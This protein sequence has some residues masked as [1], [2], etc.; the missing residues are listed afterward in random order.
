MEAATLYLWDSEND[1]KLEHYSSLLASI[2][3][4]RPQ[5]Y[6]LSAGRSPGD[7]YQFSR[8]RKALTGQ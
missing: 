1:G 6:G 5:G 7:M 3:D 4:S 8:A 2:S